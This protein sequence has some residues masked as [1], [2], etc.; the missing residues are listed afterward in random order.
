MIGFKTDPAASDELEGKEIITATTSGANPK[1]AKRERKRLFSRSR[2]R[3]RSNS[4]SSTKVSKPRR[5]LF[6]RRSKSG[7]TVATTLL[8]DD[9]SNLLDGN[10]NDQ[11]L[12]KKFQDSTPMERKRFLKG[13]GLDRA[14]QKM[15]RYFEWRKQYNLDGLASKVVRKTD[16]EVWDIAVAHTAQY[17]ESSDGSPVPS[18]VPRVVKFGDNE[19]LRALD[20]R[21]IALVLPGLIEKKLAPLDFFARCVGV[22]L[23]LKLDRNFDESIYVLVDV[24]SGLNWPNASPG[25]LLPFMKSLNKQLIDAMPERMHKTIV[26]PIPPIAKPIWA[27][28]KSFIDKKVVAK[29]SIL[30]GPASVNCPIPKGMR[31]DVFDQKVVNSIEDI[32]KSEFIYGGL[33]EG[34]SL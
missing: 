25:S 17:Y 16:S 14:E 12:E 26:Y 29:I 21:R 2:S 9:D 33:E 15:N 8:V 34:N 10:P 18:V 7:D 5:G 24:R 31:N 20:G 6:K 4:S 32:R 30:W 28:F 27:L 19:D 1:S 23:D 3:S 13:R 22:Y 11:L